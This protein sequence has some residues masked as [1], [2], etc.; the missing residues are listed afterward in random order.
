MNL[1]TVTFFLIVLGGV[2]V[3][4][5][6]RQAKGESKHMNEIEYLTFASV[7]GTLLVGI[8][9]PIGKY[10][11]AE[12]LN[13]LLNNPLASGLFFSTLGLIV[14]TISGALDRRFLIGKK[15][16]DLFQSIEIKVFGDR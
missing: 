12:A 5:S 1:D 14:G 10:A 2:I 15:L 7:W 16:K 11:D 9:A 13:K 6:F 8:Y 3:V 4:W